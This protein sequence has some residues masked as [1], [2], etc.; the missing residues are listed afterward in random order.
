M[1]LVILLTKDFSLLTWNRG[2]SN[3]EGALFN[4]DIKSKNISY[5]KYINS[6]KFK[7]I[8]IVL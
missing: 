7:K 6:N 3:R 5:D 8:K 4:K 1:E 2:I